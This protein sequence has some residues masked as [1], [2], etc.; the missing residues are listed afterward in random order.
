MPLRLIARE[1]N[2]LRAARPP[3]RL[4]CVAGTLL[5]ALALAW[6][7][8]AEAHGPLLLSPSGTHLGAPYQDW[9]HRSYVPAV[10][11]RVRVDL[12]GCP[13]APRAHGCVFSNPAT[14]YMRRGA[15]LR[16]TLH[17]EL[18]HLFDFRV[19]ND[20]DRARFKRLLGQTARRWTSSGDNSPR[21]RFAEAYSW[22]ARYRRIRS[23]GRF[24]TYGYDPSPRQHVAICRLIR[25][26]AARRRGPGPLANPPRVTRPHPP[27]SAAPDATGPADDGQPQEP[28]PLIPPLL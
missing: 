23:I 16:G 28:D 2:A 20:R 8:P 15:G 13:W 26:V 17:H 1:A 9:V 5:A 10:R 27:P 6:A 21:E 25:K 14:I 7:Q 18:G 19:L 24:T 11:G 22:C 12:T 3:A 4:A